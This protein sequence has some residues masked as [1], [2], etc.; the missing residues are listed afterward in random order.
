M[1][2]RVAVSLAANFPEAHGRLAAILLRQGEVESAMRHRR[3]ASGDFSQAGPR[4]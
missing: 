4:G 1:S 3:M 2:L